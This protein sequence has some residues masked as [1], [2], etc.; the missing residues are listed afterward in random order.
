MKALL[1]L[2][3]SVFFVSVQAATFTSTSAG[4]YGS[5]IGL[6]T[7]YYWGAASDIV[8]IDHAVTYTGD[9]TFGG[10]TGYTLVIRN[11]GSLTVTGKFTSNNGTITIE[12][13]S[14]LN[15]T[16]GLYANNNSGTFTI[17]G[18]MNITGGGISGV[19]NEWIVGSNGKLNVTGDFNND[20]DKM[21]LTV[22]G[23]V[24]V[25]GNAILT[26]GDYKIE[27][28]GSFEAQGSGDVYVN[29]ATIE[30]DGVISF[31]NVTSVTMASGGSF[32]CDG[33]GSG[34]VSFGQNI[35][36]SS[37]CTGSTGSGTAGCFNNGT[38]PLPIVLKY[39]AA[40]Q[41]GDA[42][43]FNWE[44]TQEID[45]DYFTIEYSFDAVN[46]EALVDQIAGAGNSNNP[47]A[48]EEY[49][50][51][52]FDQELVYFRLKQ[53]DFDGTT[54][55]SK[56]ISFSARRAENEVMAYP[57]PTSNSLFINIPESEVT[58][59][60]SLVNI[61]GDYSSETFY[62]SGG[63]NEINTED[64]PN[65]VYILKVPASITVNKKIV[66]QH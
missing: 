66:I 15:A 51:G 48:Y 32:D 16:N 29:L 64:I 43:V 33:S 2:L 57:N 49:Y 28:S 1:T 54:S 61:A 4:T 10:A 19:A 47:I 46:F 37:V 52:E 34:V 21:D 56:I 63:L 24:S 31:P 3:V 59:T 6:P 7:P 30:N 39:F 44:T 11:G 38:A 53:T 36:C 14:S 62:I 20:N 22:F 27:S 50:L 23:E 26:N 12:E 55:Y 13:G 58:Y 17:N 60:V 18:E 65:G 8:Y 41:S 25:T 5:G 45:N 35:D 40:E 9:L 42:V